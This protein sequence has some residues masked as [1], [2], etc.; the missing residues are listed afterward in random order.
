M[1]RLFTAVAF[2]LSTAACTG[3]TGAQGFR[4]PTLDGSY[5][6]ASDHLGKHALLITFF[7]SDCEACLT[8][9]S[10][11]NDLKRVYGPRG[12]EVIAIAVDGPE[13]RGR[14]SAQAGDAHI[15]FPV[16]LDEDSTIYNRYDP[17]H[18]LPLTLVVNRDGS[19]RERWANVYFIRPNPGLNQVIEAAV[20]D[21]PARAPESATH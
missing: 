2:T 17:S 15:D 1:R 19:V 7:T 11:F 3:V 9:M 8:Q 10:V 6:D 20:D 12:L 13:T 4:A 14:L 16:L 18:A 5:F 21:L